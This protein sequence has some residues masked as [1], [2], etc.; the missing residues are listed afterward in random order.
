MQVRGAPLI[1]IVAALGLA[2][3]LLSEFADCTDETPLSTVHDFLLCNIEFLKTSRP[4]AV[5]LFEAMGLLSSAITKSLLDQ[6]ST[7][8]FVTSFVE[9]CESLLARDIADNKAIG[10]NGATFLSQK[11]DSAPYSVLTHC[12][13][14][15]LATAGY[16]TALG[17]IRSLHSD[18][19]NLS[20]VYCTETR[21]YNQGARLTAFELHSENI[22]YTLITDSMVSYLF[23]SLKAANKPPIKAIIVGADRVCR[24]GD[25]ANK[26][27]TLQ[28]SIIANHF[29][30]DFIVAA[31]STTVDLSLQNGS[32]IPIEHRPSS[33]M[34]QVSGILINNSSLSLDRAAVSI[35]PEFNV[36]NPSF[37]VT[38]ASNISAIVT[39]K[40]VY[41]RNPISNDFDLSVSPL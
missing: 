3:H 21:P 2:S 34:L 36:W 1:A 5:N 14:G 27:G 31:P 37:D 15:A 39:E 41:T 26:I 4:T 13:T 12:N 33:E 9:L 10:K 40:F 29:G 25:V 24:N 35:A 38:P 17:I 18:S 28:L 32:Q 23:E 16:G 22:P 11:L 19:P 7:P 6:P 8:V 20:H 30:I